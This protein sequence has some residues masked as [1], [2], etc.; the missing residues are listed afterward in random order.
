ML[1]I[2]VAVHITTR[3]PQIFLDNILMVA[4]FVSAA[5]VWAAACTRP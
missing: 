4:S 2:V 1:A 3:V 5:E